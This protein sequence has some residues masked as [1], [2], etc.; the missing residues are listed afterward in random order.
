MKTDRRILKNK[1]AFILGLSLIIILGLTINACKKD[2]DCFD[3]QLYDQHKNDICTQDCPGV[4]GCDGK[5][6]C[7][8]CIANSKGIRIK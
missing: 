8:E 2:T 7:N 3:Q 1:L 5:A 4:T 6:Y